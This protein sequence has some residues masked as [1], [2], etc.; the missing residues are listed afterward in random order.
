M[1]HLSA[2]LSKLMLMYCK[3]LAHTIGIG[4]N[5][6]AQILENA[7]CAVPS[8]EISYNNYC[9]ASKEVK[10]AQSQFYTWVNNS[11]QSQGVAADIDF[12]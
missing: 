10:S 12:F 8:N 1:A 5:N 6:Q 7:C 4:A 2:P 11:T 9:F 3:C